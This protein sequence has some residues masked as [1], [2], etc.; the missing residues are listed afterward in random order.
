[1]ATAPT[2]IVT[3]SLDEGTGTRS[4]GPVT[5]LA[6]DWLVVEVIVESNTAGESFPPTAVG[7][8]AFTGQTDNGTSGSDIR[9]VQS[10][11]RETSSWAFRT[12]T[13][14][15]TG[16]SAG[17]RLWRALLTVVRGS[18]GPGTG[19]GASATAQTLSVTR[20]GANSMMFI[21]GG[22]FSTTGTLGTPTYT[23]GGVSISATDGAGAD[24]A[25]GR[26]DDSGA[27]ATVAHG[28]A[29]PTL[30]TPSI[31]VLEMLGTTPGSVDD[32]PQTVPMLLPTLA[33]DPLMQAV[34]FPMRPWQ[35]RFQW[36][37]QPWLGT[38]AEAAPPVSAPAAEPRGGPVRAQPTPAIA[39]R[40]ASRDGAFIAVIPQVGPPVRPAGGPVQ[41]R[42]LPV[43]GGV[44]QGRDG[45]F[46]SVGPAV[47]AAHGPVTSPRVAPTRGGRVAARAGVWTAPAPTTGPPIYPLHHPAQARQLPQ[48]G[49]HT[50]RAT[51]PYA[52]VGPAVKPAD[53]PVRAQPAPT[54]GGHVTSRAGLLTVGAPQAGPPIYLTG[55]PV[56]AKRVPA[57]SGV[58]AGRDG[59]YAGSGP[60][61]P[62]L[63]RPVAAPPPQARGGRV[64]ARTGTPVA[65]APQTGPPVYPLHRPAGARRL[66]GRGG[67]V[68]RRAGPYSGV[69]PAA[70]Q[71]RQ[72]MSRGRLQPPPPARGRTAALRGTWQGV[73]PPL[74][75]LQRPVRARLPGPVRI[76]RAET[77]LLPAV[78]VPPPTFVIGQL[79][80]TI[81]ANQVTASVYAPTGSPATYAPTPSATDRRTGGP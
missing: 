65:V 36:V 32:G 16:G 56:Q 59:V 7:M 48:R 44:A 74:R 50:L 62:P 29:T 22:D 55:H 2:A 34:V 64:L 46:A 72:P 45:T 30:T 1:M 78:A 60:T 8:A 75:P 14:T 23:P 47:E 3:Q 68:T 52:G 63:H 6:G 38:D 37:T 15:P 5:A 53:G 41:V 43:R 31:A 10:T 24:Y 57:R 51:G 40:V 11:V 25:F 66:P 76:G 26:W 54:R 4:F 70:P 28:I 80:A 12:V 9:V 13:V 21:S 67:C 79:S 61:V 35:R 20:Q 42:R 58:V 81:A 39:G 19:K 27:T 69:G 17:T 33:Y 49:G 71:L 18:A 73:G 77:T